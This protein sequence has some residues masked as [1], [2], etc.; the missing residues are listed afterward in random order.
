MTTLRDRAT[1]RTKTIAVVALPL[2]LVGAFALASYTSLFATRD[3]R[4]E[5]AATLTR[6]DVLRLAGI[7][8][9]TN[10]FHLDADAVARALVADPWIATASVERH[11]P[12][13]IVIR[14]QEREPIA[15]ST[16]GLAT[17]VLAG[18]G[19]ALPGASAD[20]LPEIRASVG[21]PSDD[22]R[23]GAARALAALERILRA[24]VA[25]VVVEP[26]GELVMDLAG[27]LTVHYGS[28]GDDAAKAT[29]LHAVLAWAAAQDEPLREV[30]VTVPEAPSATLVGGSTFTP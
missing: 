10:V 4:I 29:A 24:R 5:G 18:D 26:S 28:P 20:G 2:I 1:R 30:D 3:I 17:V 19:V 14:L 7:G 22:A 25:A 8:P 6:E 9:G 23:A 11:L 12:G 21:E 15:R 16:V 13:T 27:D